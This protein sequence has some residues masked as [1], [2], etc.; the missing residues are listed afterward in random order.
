[1]LALRYGSKVIPAALYKGGIAVGDRAKLSEILDNVKAAV[2][3]GDLGAVMA[4]AKA[5]ES[6]RRAQS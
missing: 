6:A 5:G 2:R 1:L 3:R 4:V